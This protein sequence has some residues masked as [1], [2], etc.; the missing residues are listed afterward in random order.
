MLLLLFDCEDD[1]QTTVY[2]GKIIMDSFT[3][4]IPIRQFCFIVAGQRNFLTSP[5]G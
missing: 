5:K 3:V 4:N 2:L 1:R